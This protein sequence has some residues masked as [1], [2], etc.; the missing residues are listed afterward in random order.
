MH[1]QK[2]VSARKSYE[3]ILDLPKAAIQ[4]VTIIYFIGSGT[5]VCADTERAAT[6]FF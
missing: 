2:Q 3:S 1:G 4:M 6:E 5:C